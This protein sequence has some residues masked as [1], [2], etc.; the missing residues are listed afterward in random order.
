[1]DETFLYHQIADAIRKDILTGR[2]K[3]GDRVPSVRQLCEDW[4]CTPG[5]IQRAYS[6]LAREGLLVSRAGRGTQVAGVIP[7]A[8]TQGQETIRRASLVNRMEST[9]LEA[10]TAGYDLN[11]IQQAMDLAMDR[12]RA[13]SATHEVQP[14]ETLR[15]AGSHD[16]VINDLAHFYFG[17]VIQGITL[18]LSYSG[19]LG[20]LIALVEGKADL[21]GCHLWDAESDTYNIPFIR[22]LLPGK[23]VTIVTLAHRRI[24]LIVAPGNPHNIGG[25]ADLLRPGVRFVNRQSGS[26]TRVWLDATLSGMGLDHKIIDG[27]ADERLTHSDVAR[28]VAEGIADVGLGLESAAQAYSLDFIFLNKERYDLVMTSETAS[29]PVIQKLITWLASPE[30]KHFVNR[31]R[32]YDSQASGEVQQDGANSD[33]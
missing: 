3:P 12:W 14:T 33:L 17:Q 23:E 26:G 29:Q 1:M 21:A 22:R 19:S 11:E 10:L 27:Y 2:Y 5:T 15:F 18:Q 9:L 7:L 20:G 31:H 8:K 32:G 28:A 4:N 25:L 24:G 13:L 6:E 30:G 16:M